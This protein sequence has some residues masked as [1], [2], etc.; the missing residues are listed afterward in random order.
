MFIGDKANTS[1]DS[2][3]HINNAYYMNNNYTNNDGQSHLKLCGD[4]STNCFNIK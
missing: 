3:F 2:N 1:K 4:S